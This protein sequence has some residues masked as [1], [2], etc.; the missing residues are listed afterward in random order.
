MQPQTVPNQN[1]SITKL[2][3]NSGLWI[4]IRFGSGFNDF[5]DPEKIFMNNTGIFDLILLKF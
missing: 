1:H 2:I 4:Q 3:L 5:V